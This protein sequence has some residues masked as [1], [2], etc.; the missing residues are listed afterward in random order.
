MRKIIALAILGAISVSACGG[1]R[2]DCLDR[3]QRVA[4][5]AAIADKELVQGMGEYEVRLVLGQPDEI[6]D[7]SGAGDQK[8]WK[9][10]VLA[11]CHT[12]QGLGA[13]TTELVFQQGALLRWITYGR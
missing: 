5:V 12:V 4:H 1:L 7:Y 9:Y 13:P 6:I 11:D 8:V 3:Q 10:N 2:Q